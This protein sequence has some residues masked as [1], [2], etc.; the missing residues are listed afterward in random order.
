MEENIIINL[1]S[2]SNEFY[3]VFFKIISHAVSWIGAL[4]IF[5]VILMFVNKK[6]GLTFGF[7]LLGIVGV[8]YL[9]KM[10]VN[11]PRPFEVNELII[12]KLSTIGMSFPS[13]HMV[14]ATFIV[15]SVLFLIRQ[16]LKNK[17]SKL[18]NN[19]WIWTS[20]FIAGAIIIL[21]A[22]LSRMYLGQHYLTDLI[23][24]FVVGILGFIITCQ[25]YK[26][27]EKK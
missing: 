4:I 23:G 17:N 9:I 1:Q 10:I 6:F 5:F 22:G 20:L 2:A 11:R 18:K 25:I 16:I 14:S 7:G 24:G 19:K 21:L 8:N 26:K 27:V 12:N 3:D 13:G 15:C